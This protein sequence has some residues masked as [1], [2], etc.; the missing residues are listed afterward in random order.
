MNTYETTLRDGRIV[1]IMAENQYKAR[2]K[3]MELYGARN[4]PYLPHLIP[5]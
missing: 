3:L 5:H 2:E 1:T 4:V